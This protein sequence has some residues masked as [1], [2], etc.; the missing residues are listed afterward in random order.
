VT[1]NP[2]SHPGDVRKFKAVDIPELR[3]LYNVV[4]FSTKGDRPD[5]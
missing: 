4:V 5:E 1:K 3:Y 2:C